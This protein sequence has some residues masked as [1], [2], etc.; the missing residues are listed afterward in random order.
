MRTERN[1]EDE[2]R[3]ADVDRWPDIPPV[4]FDPDPCR[5]L[6][7]KLRTLQ[8]ARKL[9]TFPITPLPKLDKRWRYSRRD[10]SHSWNAR[11]AAVGPRF[12]G[13]RPEKKPRGL[14]RAAGGGAHRDI[15]DEHQRA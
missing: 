6:D 3:R 2:G 13:A 12:G 10:G 15:F 8:K 4:C 11:R 14:N 9:G 5:L 7:L 1:G